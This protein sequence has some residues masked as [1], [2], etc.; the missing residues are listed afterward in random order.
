[1]NEARKLF[2]KSQDIANKYG[3]E[4]LAMKISNEH[5]ELLKQLDIWNKL[6]DSGAS[7]AERIELSRLD[8]Q[9]K[10]MLSKR[11]A[12]I[13]KIADEEPVLLL[14]VSEGGVPIF[15]Q[16]FVKDQSFEDHLFGGFFTAINSFINEK[17]SEGLDRAIFGD[18]TLLMESVSPFFMCYV[19]KG[20]SYAAQHR[21]RYFIE[22]IQKDEP[23]WQTFENYYQINKEVQLK[24][25][26][27]LDPLI[28]E[29]FIDKS[30]QIE[31][32]L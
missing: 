26:P 18:H 22:K 28:K 25:I 7:L 24:D 19:F 17:F 12:E 27:S 14:I 3:L 1:M 20:Q 8:G 30:I 21:I 23:I 2:T 31:G 15:S 4:L 9:M 5:D 29:I 32:L 11:L 10:N 16:S 13:P 6:K